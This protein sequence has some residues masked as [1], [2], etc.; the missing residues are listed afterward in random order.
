[1]DIQNATQTKPATEKSVQKLNNVIVKVG[2]KLVVQKPGSM[3]SQPPRRPAP[4][5][6]EKIAELL[7]RFIREAKERD[8]SESGDRRRHTPEAK[9]LSR[10][11]KIIQNY[12]RLNSRERGALLDGAKNALEIREIKAIREAGGASIEEIE[13]AVGQV[14]A[15]ITEAERMLDDAQRPRTQRPQQYRQFQPTTAP[16]ATVVDQSAHHEE[17]AA[18]QLAPIVLETA[19]QRKERIAA[20]EQKQRLARQEREKAHLAREQQRKS[21]QHYGEMKALAPAPKQKKDEGKG[22]KGKRD[23]RAQAQA[24]A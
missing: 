14:K 17:P 19:E 2:G 21:N 5:T 3:T 20:D 15:W 8:E 4:L 1:M 6:P 18:S 13:A 11:F 7:P 23:A 22:K 9:A 16:V 10:I 12:E 24:R